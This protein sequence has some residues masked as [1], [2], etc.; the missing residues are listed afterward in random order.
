MLSGGC[1]RIALSST[2]WSRR[3]H[4]LP[5]VV[6]S[7]LNT[8]HEPLYV[9]AARGGGLTLQVLAYELGSEWE[10]SLVFL[11]ERDLSCLP[12]A[13]LWGLKPLSGCSFLTA[14][15][16]SDGLLGAWAVGL[17]PALPDHRA[18]VPGRGP[19]LSPAP[20]QT[21]LRILCDDPCPGGVPALAGLCLVPWKDRAWAA[22][23]MEVGLRQRMRGRS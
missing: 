21:R 13:G 7:V 17:F 2:T 22:A 9:R 23:R 4:K 8:A 10:E 12:R 1:K 5:Q 16:C 19:L 11:P 18:H 20:A 14:W 15:L 3:L 6:I